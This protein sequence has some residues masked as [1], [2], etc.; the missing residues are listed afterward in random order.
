[1][2]H[3]P[4]TGKR[5]FFTRCGW[6]LSYTLSILLP[7][8]PLSAYLLRLLKYSTTVLIVSSVFV[9]PGRPLFVECG[10]KSYRQYYFILCRAAHSPGYFTF[11]TL[12]WHIHCRSG[13]KLMWS[14]LRRV[15][16]TKKFVLCIGGA[17]SHISAL[18][19][20]YYSLEFDITDASLE[21]DIE[22]CSAGQ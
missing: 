11:Q 8:P 14:A 4:H 13:S 17:A 7:P 19:L 15:G 5:C 20:D 9:G 18:W 3:R 12:I 2:P 10:V 1:M 22:Q 21:L 16:Q 6:L